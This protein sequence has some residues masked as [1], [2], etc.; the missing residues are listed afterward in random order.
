MGDDREARVASIIQELKE[1]YAK[2]QGDLFIFLFNYFYPQVRTKSDSGDYD[3]EAGKY[4]CFCHF[5]P[6]EKQGAR[7]ALE[8]LAGYFDIRYDSYN[9]FFTQLDIYAMAI[10][11]TCTDEEFGTSHY[12]WYGEESDNFHVSVRTN[13]ALKDEGFRAKIEEKGSEQ[14]ELITKI[15]EKM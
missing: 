10:P 6:T 4:N 2:E 7:L 9:S 3:R 5:L 13:L 15:M 8:E 1:E 14:F 11:N 12:A